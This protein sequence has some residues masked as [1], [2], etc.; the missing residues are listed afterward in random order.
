MTLL[1]AAARTMLASYFVLNGVKTLRNP[2]ELVPATQPLADTVVPLAKKVAPEQVVDYIPT[3]TVTF[4]RANGAVQVLGGLAL[5]TGKARRLG[6]LLL[7]GTILP[8]TLTNHAFWRAE[9]DDEKSQLK[10]GFVKDVA[11]IGGVLIAAQDTEGKPSLMWRAQATG[12]RGAK[13]VSRGSKKAAKEAKDL[14]KA[15]RRDLGF[16]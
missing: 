6:A 5:A 12:E 10:D 7:A 1:R 4:V 15:A 8:N 2:H 14:A 11:L 9:D 3:D 16:K 13:K